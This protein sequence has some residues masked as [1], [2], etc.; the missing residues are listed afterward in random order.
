ME[1]RLLLVHSPLVGCGAWEPI[2]KDLAGD[3]YAVVVPD[4]GGTL[5]AGPPYHLRQARR[6]A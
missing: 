1:A 3:G 6:I 5:A 4:L 2:A